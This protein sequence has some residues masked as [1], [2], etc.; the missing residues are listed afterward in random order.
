MTGLPPQDPALI[1]ALIE[2]GKRAERERAEAVAPFWLRVV[3]ADDRLARLRDDPEA[4]GQIEALLLRLRDEAEV[5]PFVR[6]WSRPEVEALAER[7]LA[8]REELAT[9]VDDARALRRAAAGGP[10][11][12][13]A[14][15][16]AFSLI[17]LFD[18]EELAAAETAAEALLAAPGKAGGRG[19]YTANT[20]PRPVAVFGAALVP[21]FRRAGIPLGGNANRD[22][23]FAAFLDTA[24]DFAIGGPIPGR[25][26]LFA[27]LRRL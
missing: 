14:G 24:H 6:E 15:A 1:A 17:D 18:R 10:L 25:N 19:G 9:L 2:A 21:L 26:A 27:D 3:A 20:R 5:N 7:V 8:L 16:M 22:K 23:A 11:D 12:G 4:R 13:P